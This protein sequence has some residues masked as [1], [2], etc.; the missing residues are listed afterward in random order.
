MT[1]GDKPLYRIVLTGG[2]CGG[3]STSL[4]SI[5]ERVQGLGFEVYRTCGSSTTPPTSPTRSS[6]SSPPS[7]RSL[8][9]PSPRRLNPADL[10]LFR[11]EGETR[12][13]SRLK[14]KDQGRDF[15]SRSAGGDLATC[16]APGGQVEKP[17][18]ARIYMVTRPNGHKIAM[19]PHGTRNPSEDQ[20]S[21][22]S[23]DPGLVFRPPRA[24]GIEC[25]SAWR[26]SARGCT[27]ETYPGP[28]AFSR[29]GT[30]PGPFSL[31]GPDQSDQPE[32]RS[33]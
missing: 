20:G 7:A 18:G 2:P 13:A 29:E 19:A 5:A 21:P 8:E 30:A 12:C 33:P 28:V 6:G 24:D 10:C 11:P 16:R 27:G 14:P 3:K 32:R 9:C 15:L 4:S 31:P 25:P 23:W 1:V 22:F 17:H 26:R